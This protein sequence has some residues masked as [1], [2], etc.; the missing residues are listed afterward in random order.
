MEVQVHVNCGFPQSIGPNHS[1]LAHFDIGHPPWL[2]LITGV[3]CLSLLPL[4]PRYYG[5]GDPWHEG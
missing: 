4:H 1:L 2:A 3:L 5:R